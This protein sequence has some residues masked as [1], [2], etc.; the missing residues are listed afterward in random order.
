MGGAD[1]DVD[2][3]G[4]SSRW[5]EKAREQLAVDIADLIALHSPLP[6]QL[7]MEAVVRSFPV[8]RLLLISVS[9]G[10]MTPHYCISRGLENHKFQEKT[11]PFCGHPGS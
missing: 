5:H 2:K 11:P 8:P 3:F 7:V 10:H 1:A 6:S 4:F 9:L